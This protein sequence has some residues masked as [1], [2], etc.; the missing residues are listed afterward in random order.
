MCDEESEMSTL[1][2]KCNDLWRYF[3]FIVPMR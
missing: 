1:E 2:C 3:L